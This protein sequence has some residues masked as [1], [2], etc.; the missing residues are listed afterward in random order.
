MDVGQASNSQRLGPASPITYLTAL[1]DFLN[2]KSLFSH[3]PSSLSARPASENT[4]SNLS[5]N[6]VDGEAPMT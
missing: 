3:C 4:L 5:K 2:K 1:V 6:D